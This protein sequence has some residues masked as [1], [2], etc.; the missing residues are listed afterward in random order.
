MIG[1]HIKQF[2]TNL[3]YHKERLSLFRTIGSYQLDI[4]SIYVYIHLYF[5]DIH[6]ILY[7]YNILDISYICHTTGI[8]YRVSIPKI[9]EERK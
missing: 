3:L 7:I 6:I 8:N 5:R 2:Y 1:R 4:C 9:V